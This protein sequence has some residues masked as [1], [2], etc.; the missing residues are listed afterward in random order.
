MKCS[1]ILE[2]CFPIYKRCLFLKI[3]VPLFFRN[4]TASS[5][6]TLLSINGASLVAQTV[7]NLPAM[8]ESWVWCLDWE[9]PLEEGMVT[10]SNILVLE[11][12]WT[13]D[14]V[15]YSPWSHI[16]SDTTGHT[17]TQSVENQILHTEFLF[18]HNR[19]SSIFE[20][21]LKCLYST[22][23]WIANESLFTFSNKF[24][25]SPCLWLRQ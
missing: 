18:L 6:S 11:V 7:K 24:T 20:Y 16:A 8:L 12:P 4:F 22:V 21:Y 9:D 10:H 14:L 1:W 23:T 15:G 2:Q 17:H 3:L 13:E 25:F 5:Y 19:L